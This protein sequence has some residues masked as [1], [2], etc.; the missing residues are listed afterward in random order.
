MD[1]ASDISVSRRITRL[2]ARGVRTPLLLALSFSELFSGAI[3]SG[4][5]AVASPPGVARAMQA[6]AFGD[7]GWVAPLP[8]G[9]PLKGDPAAPG[10]RVAEREREP[11]GEAILRAPFRVALLPVRVLARGLEALAGVDITPL[12]TFGRTHPGSSVGPSFSYS[13]GAG[14]GIG[15]RTVSVLDR[16]HAA[17]L[18]AEGTWSMRDTRKLRA[19]ID[20]G[21]AADP[22]GIDLIT[23]YAFEPNRRF[24]GIGNASSEDDRT[25]FLREGG[26]ADGAVR[27]GPLERELRAIGGF[28]ASSAR[29]GY[30]GGTDVLDRLT[31]AEAPGL[32]GQSR[33]V[34]FGV[35]GD[36]ATLDNLKNPSRGAETRI[37]VRQV[38]SLSGG[39]FDFRRYRFE[40]RAYLPVFSARRVIALRAVQQ[41][42]APLRDAATI[43][44]YLLPES[45][46][47]TH[48]AAYSGHRFTDRHL[49]LAHAEYRWLVWRRV[50][51]LGLAELGEVASRANR[52]RFADVHESYGGGVRLAF[53][54]TSVA[55]LQIAR[56]S[57]G[58]AAHLSLDGDF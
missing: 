51:V 9:A 41:S 28:E 34:S 30:N 31:L 27:F 46:G 43:P 56:G 45:A 19:G 21:A 57:E 2:R 58:I 10:P 53:S 14:L 26:A 3:C 24:Y 18:S 6:P 40:A 29:G 4:A 49:A 23:T 33:R 44:F 38:H 54:E 36:F 1:R 50:W 52:L 32:F 35:G 39:D 5:P 17:Q 47:E 48:F 37:E 20:W 22:W 12:N 55:R 11:T 7:S 16:R 15:L 13:G 42:V 8:A 25:I